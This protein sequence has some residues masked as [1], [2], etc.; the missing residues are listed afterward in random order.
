MDLSM[1]LPLTNPACEIVDDVVWEGVAPAE[2]RPLVRRWL[3]RSLALPRPARF[4]PY[5]R[6]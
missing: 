3:G 5:C 2:P 4:A 6:H 1:I